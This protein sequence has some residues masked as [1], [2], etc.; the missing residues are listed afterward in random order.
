[1]PEIGLFPLGLV[2]LPSERVPLHVF[3]PRYKE[4]VGECIAEDDVFG[5]VLED[6]DGRRDVGT[7][8]AVIDVV[9]TFDDGRM[10][11]V[12]EGRS[13]FSVDTWTDGRS[14]P[15]GAVKLIEDD[16]PAAL[17]PA[18]VERVLELFRRLAEVADADVDDPDPASG[19]LSFEVASHVDF[20][21]SPKQELLELRSESERLRRL[22]E[23]LDAAL[24][25]M[26]REREIKE[27]A[28]TNGRVT[29][30]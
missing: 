9:H 29:T 12:V 3:E 11:I 14:F 25:A 20:G 6:E 23:F 8:A 10:N 28:S 13:R 22:A 15:T 2:L 26:T 16:D 24:T 18:D 4:L 17:D 1:M 21:T 30:D 5:I 7:I 19:T 27:R